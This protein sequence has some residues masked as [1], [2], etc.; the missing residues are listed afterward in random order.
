MRMTSHAA[1]TF[2][3]GGL[4]LALVAAVAVLPGCYAKRF[5]GYDESI[6]RLT[7]QADSLAGELAKTRSELA[8]AKTQLASHE[9]TMKSLRAGTQTS[10]E[11]LIGRIDQLE[12]RFEDQSAQLN[13]LAGRAR[14][15]GAVLDSAAA[16][17]SVPPAAPTGKTG[18]DKSG[19][20]G[21]GKTS[22]ANPATVQVDPT[23]AYDQAVLDFTQGR[24]PLA[25]TEF[26]AFVTAHGTTDLAD[27]AQYGVG[28]S[29]YAQGQYDSAA[30]AYRAVIDG[31]PDGDKVPAALY[32][33]G[34]A[35]QKSNRSPEARTTFKTL[36]DK[37]PRTGEARLA[38][39]RLKEMDQR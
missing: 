19:K 24:F 20:G 13:D 14:T 5:R 15:R 37:Y 17:S 2:H 33:L 16:P 1:R 34:I 32:K 30:V 28:E 38:E 6:A 4:A 36:I 7:A 23:A 10:S 22:T 29:Y 11:E 25:L 31:Y 3:R 12:A 26:R 18:T 8:D 9:Q 39:E 21:S 35:Y 27:N